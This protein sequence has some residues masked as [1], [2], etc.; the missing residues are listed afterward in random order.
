MCRS[1]FHTETIS[2]AL[3]NPNK[4]LTPYYM[5]IFKQL[6]QSTSRKYKVHCN[7]VKVQRGLKVGFLFPGKH[8]LWWN[9]PSWRESFNERFLQNIPA[10]ARDL[11][12]AAPPEPL[13]LPYVNSQFH[14]SQKQHERNK[15]RRLLHPKKWKIIFSKRQKWDVPGLPLNHS[16]LQIEHDAWV[17]CNLLGALLARFASRVGF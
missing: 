15:R 4:S 11:A 14:Y 10:R 7:P 3:T 12:V 17:I 2:E 5:C 13:S 8:N 1:Y 6:T 9:G 16:Q